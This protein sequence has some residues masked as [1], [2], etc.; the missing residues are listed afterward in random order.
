M[1]VILF[2]ALELD[3]IRSYVIYFSV[4]VIKHH[5]QGNF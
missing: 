5:D 1:V 4:A 2:I 3:D